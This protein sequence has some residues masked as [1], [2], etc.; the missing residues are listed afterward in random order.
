[1]PLIMKHMG[2]SKAEATKLMIKSSELATDVR[3]K[4]LREKGTRSLVAASI[5]PYG[6][7]TETLAEYSGLYGKTT[8]VK[9]MAAV[10]KN[11]FQLYVDKTTVD[12]VAFETIPCRQE[13]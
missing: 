6:A 8:P 13:V 9:T 3:D 5:G 11:S 4:Q 7:L 2:V 12:L 10:H 1:M